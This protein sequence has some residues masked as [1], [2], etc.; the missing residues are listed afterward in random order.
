MRKIRIMILEKEN[1]IYRKLCNKSSK[2]AE[3]ANARSTYLIRI[4]FPLN[5][6]KIINER[7]K[8]FKYL[9]QSLDYAKLVGEC[10]KKIK[11]LEE[12]Q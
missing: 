3:E 4:G 5:S 10:N 7:K 12:P 6:E 8:Y 11:I 1:D 2:K 9:K